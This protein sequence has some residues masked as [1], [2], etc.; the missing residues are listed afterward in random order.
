MATLKQSE[1]RFGD[2]YSG[3]LII[4]DRAA[5]TNIN[6]LVTSGIYQIQNPQNPP[7]ASATSWDNY[8]TVIVVPSGWNNDNY[9]F[10]IAFKLG[11]NNIYFRNKY[12]G[13]GSWVKINTTSA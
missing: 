9:C 10:Q 5:S 2:D 12:D 4:K 13:W 11:T 8:W 6:D 7:V 3:G 1:L